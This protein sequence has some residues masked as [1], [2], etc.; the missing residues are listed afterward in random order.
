MSYVCFS[1]EAAF[2]QMVNE[3]G[4]GWVGETVF[5]VMYTAKTSDSDMQAE[6]QCSVFIRWWW[7]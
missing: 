4:R 2:L 3:Q 1:L 5:N 6:L 7:W